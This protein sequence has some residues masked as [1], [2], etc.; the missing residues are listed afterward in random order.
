VPVNFVESYTG[1]FEDVFARRASGEIVGFVKTL[2]KGRAMMFG[3]ALPANTLEDL[4][5]LH[6]MALRMDCHPLFELSEWA[7]VRAS[8]G[9]RGTFLFINNY[10][11]DPISTTIAYEGETLFDGNPVQLP[12]RRGLILP[13]EGQLHDDVLLHYATGEV[14]EITAGDAGIT[15]SL[16]P[17]E[18]VAELTLSGYRCDE[19]TIIRESGEKSRV[20]VH[21][22]DGRIVLRKVT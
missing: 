3:A 13:L 6:Q 22:Q 10:Q 12:A 7:D 15:L 21:G 4:D 2:G 14:A 16:V 1:R 9:D 19:A 8:R 17:T 5:V 18:F 20:Q 11:D